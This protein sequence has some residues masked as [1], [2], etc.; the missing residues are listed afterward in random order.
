MQTVQKKKKSN[1]VLTLISK[2]IVIW[3]SILPSMKSEW[4]GICHQAAAPQLARSWW[5]PRCCNAHSVWT[6]LSAPVCVQLVKKPPQKTNKLYSN[7]PDSIVYWDTLCVCVTD[8]A[9]I[10]QVSWVILN[11][12]YHSDSVPADALGLRS[13]QS[14]VQMT[15][16]CPAAVDSVSVQ[17][18]KNMYLLIPIAV[19][20]ALASSHL[21]RIKVWNSEE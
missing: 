10:K 2:E 12:K 1:I 17:W 3:C 6:T 16:R 5:L 13:A 11:V 18:P 20:S 4:Q 19:L 15:G 21:G 7:S 8:A 9:E 14:Q